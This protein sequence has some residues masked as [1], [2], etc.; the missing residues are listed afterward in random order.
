MRR[1]KEPDGPNH[2]SNGLKIDKKNQEVGYPKNTNINFG[3]SF[4]SRMELNKHKP[5]SAANSATG[6]NAHLIEL[7]FILKNFTMVQ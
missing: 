7:L 2:S 5:E 3:S 6:T 4:P 1:G